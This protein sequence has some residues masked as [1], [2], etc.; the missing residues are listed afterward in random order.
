M[1]LLLLAIAGYS[2]AGQLLD[3][4]TE[5][6]YGP[7]TISVIYERDLKLNLSDPAAID[8]LVYRGGDA[9]SG[10]AYTGLT[11]LGLGLT[12]M[13]FAVLPIATGWLLLAGWLGREHTRRYHG[14]DPD[15]PV[16]GDPP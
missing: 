2:A 10:W 1:L 12:G 6:V 15:Y 3:D 16:H 14:P 11:S 5:L 4:S 9:L 13:A 7:S 8:T